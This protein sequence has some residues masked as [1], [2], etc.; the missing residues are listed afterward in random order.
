M[1]LQFL[2]AAAALV[3]S[4]T[5]AGAAFAEPLTAKLQQP[6]AAKTKLIAGGAVFVCEGD[7]CTAAAATSRTFATN[8]CK[9]LAKE[10]GALA[11]Y[12][13]ERRQFD[14]AKLGQCNASAK[15]A[16]QVANR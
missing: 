6:V 16:T 5:A 1:K 15:P 12:G 13:S 8:A 14:E 7:A 9:D 3:L 10:V 4:T 11:G 2:A